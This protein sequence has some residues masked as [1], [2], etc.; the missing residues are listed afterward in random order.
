MGTTYPPSDMSQQQALPGTGYAP[1][2]PAVASGHASSGPPLYSYHGQPHEPELAHQRLS[3]HPQSGLHDIQDQHVTQS[4]HA[5]SQ[6]PPSN[7]NSAV[8]HFHSQTQPQ[9]ANVQL[10]HHIPPPQMQP[11]PTHPPRHDG[12]RADPATSMTPA[13]AKHAGSQQRLIPFSKVDDNTGR[14]YQ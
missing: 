2:G 3:R 10:Q 11:P 8:H 9:S 6:G 13:S 12:P 7:T 1:T 4:H 5:Q 14:K